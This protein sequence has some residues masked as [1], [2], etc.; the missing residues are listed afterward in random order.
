MFSGKNRLYLLAAAA[1]FIGAAAGANHTRAETL[2]WEPNGI[3]LGGDGSWDITSPL[4]SNGATQQTYANS[5]TT[6]AIFAGTVGT[7][8]LN[9]TTAAPI[10]A[11]I[12]RQ[13]GS[14][15]RYTG[16]DLETPDIQLADSASANIA[17]N[18]VGNQDLTIKQTDSSAGNIAAFLNDTLNINSLKVTNDIALP[19]KRRLQQGR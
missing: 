8:T 5:L 4:W 2:F 11:G 9:S 19:T 7:V 12:M 16:G 6:E 15:F 3:S 10:L 17:T 1:A 18:L 14:V 13:S